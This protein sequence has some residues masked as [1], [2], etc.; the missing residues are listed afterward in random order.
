MGLVGLVLLREFLNRI[1][2]KYDR[3]ILHRS[4][5]ALRRTSRQ[6]ST[7]NT[8]SVNWDSHDRG[9]CDDPPH[10]AI[11]LPRDEE[12]N[13]RPLPRRQGYVPNVSEQAI[14][15]GIHMLQFAVAYMVMLVAMYFNGYFNI[16]IFIGAFVGFFIFSW[17]AFGA[18]NA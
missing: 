10:S 14:R 11:P 4:Q 8:S 15:A 2:C 13:L 6:H 9:S 16:Y 12:R 3:H 1:Q 17:D 5:R 18:P 7:S